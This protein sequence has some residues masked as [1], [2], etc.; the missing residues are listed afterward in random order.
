MSTMLCLVRERK[1]WDDIITSGGLQT[2]CCPQRETEVHSTAVDRDAQGGET[3]Q[4]D[5][6]S[7]RI[8]GQSLSPD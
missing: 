7:S 6:H 5:L 4:A 2:V 1:A 8:D 3:V